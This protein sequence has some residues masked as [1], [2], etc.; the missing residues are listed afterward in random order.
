MP[1]K[2]W[3]NPD[4]T[5][6]HAWTLNY[7]WWTLEHKQKNEQNWRKFWVRNQCKHEQGIS[8]NTKWKKYS[9]CK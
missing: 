3:N 6:H 7:E 5:K 9:H 1:Y 8:M 2:R 4:K